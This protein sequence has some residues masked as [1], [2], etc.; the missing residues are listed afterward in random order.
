[1]ADEVRVAPEL[2]AGI[3]ARLSAEGMPALVEDLRRLNPGGLGSL[4]TANPRRVTR[5]L[6]RCMAS[7]ESLASLGA[8]FSAQPGP[9]SGWNVELTELVRPPAEL[10]QRIAGRAR[11]MLARGLV[12]E[13]TRLRAA[14]L[15]RN[16]SA[17]RAIGYR[18]TI[19]FL[20]GRL[21]G[22][23]LESEIVKNTRALVKKQRTW[24]RTQL[25]A[26]RSVVDL[27]IAA[28]L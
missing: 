8:A 19:A 7:G 18:E 12:E 17:A 9:F 2:R 15:G 14:G 27:S 13:V 5:A 25:P 1:V 21:P 6:E 10:D 22:D 28:D 11:D 24:F 20:E 4:D 3:A 16:P 26:T 23:M